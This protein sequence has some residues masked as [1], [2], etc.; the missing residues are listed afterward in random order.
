MSRLRLKLSLLQKR[1]AHSQQVDLH[2]WFSPQ[3]HEKLLS[4][5]LLPPEAG[6]QV[7]LKESF[8]TS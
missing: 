8:K 5:F 7:T 3:S 1:D 2:V 6:K 4:R